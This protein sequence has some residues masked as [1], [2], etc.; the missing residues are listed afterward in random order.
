[1]TPPP[2]VPGGGGDVSGAAMTTSSGDWLPVRRVML[3]AAACLRRHEAA[4]RPVA[5]AAVEAVERYADL[6]ADKRDLWLSRRAFSPLTPEEEVVRD[7]TFVS[8]ARR[9][10]PLLLRR[11]IDL[12][13]ERGGF[14]A[15]FTET[16]AQA[17]LER[18]VYG[19]V[20]RPRFLPGWQTSTALAIAAGVYADR[21]FDR[22]PVL[23]DAL[24]DAGC[25][26][27]E[28]LAHLRG[29]GPH[30]RGCWAL[31]LVLGKS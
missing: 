9:D 22:L 26:S 19:P 25:D 29:P 16:D 30:V 31:D 4:L 18:E 21:A 20:A 15:A 3:H 2:P 17:V 24:E 1:M 12:A 7:L 10:Y 8:Y 27:P 28:L 5:V 6:Q 14:P 11:L 13:G 23:A